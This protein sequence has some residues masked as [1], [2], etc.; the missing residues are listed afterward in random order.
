M[1]EWCVLVQSS[2]AEEWLKGFIVLQLVQK[3]KRKEGAL[4]FC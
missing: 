1:S 2:A 3:K 4:S